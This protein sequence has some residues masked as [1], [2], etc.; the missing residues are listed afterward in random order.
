MPRIGKSVTDLIQDVVGCT[1]PCDA[2]WRR[3]IWSTLVQMLDGTKPLPEPILAYH[4]WGPLAFIL[5][6]CLLESHYINPEVVL[7][8][9]TFEITTLLIH[10]CDALIFI[11]A[12]MD[13]EIK[14]GIPIIEN[15]DDYGWLRLHENNFLTENDIYFCGIYLLPGVV[16]ALLRNTLK[17]SRTL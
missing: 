17:L 2:I 4:Q 16:R 11:L 3:K 10:H 13:T 7:E 9:Y 14:Q 8:I 1:C 5:G 12:L 6:Y 15:I